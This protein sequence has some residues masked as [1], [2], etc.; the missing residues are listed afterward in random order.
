[1]TLTIVESRAYPLGLANIDT[2][3]IIGSD[4]LKTVSKVGLGKGAFGALR[5]NRAAVF[6]D[7][8]FAGSE[9][10]IA[11]ANFGC[12]S[13]REHAAWALAD[14][15]IRVVIA[16]SFSDIFSSNAFK[17]GI[18]AAQVDGA[19]IP[20]LMDAARAGQITVDLTEQMIT[21]ADG[22]ALR[23]EIE[24]FRRECLIEGL[25]EI[26]L[27]LAET[28]AIA[29]HEGRANEEAPWLMTIGN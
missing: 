28:E 10:L 3:V 6:D 18:L 23:F 16:P 29:A 15:G 14:F 24:P 5:E 9:I 11:G 4:W 17:N 19:A 26:S 7:P 27:T 25:N 22:A 20:A 2:D 21:S 8:E 12:G 13:S 1:M